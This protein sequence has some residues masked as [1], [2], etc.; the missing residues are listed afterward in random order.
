VKK[1]LTILLVEDN[2]GD[3]FLIRTALKEHQLTHELHVLTDGLEAANYIERVGESSETPC[4]DVLLLDLNLPQRDGH[5]LLQLFRAHPVCRDKPV[6]ICTSSSAE[7]DRKRAA[8][9]GATRYF[10]KPS[11]V[12]EFL[13]LGAV[14]REVI[15]PTATPR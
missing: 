10:C 13:T 6:I 11:D 5:E 9:L 15:E 14:V 4:P 12:D 3:I 1:P 7:R 8:E 2:R